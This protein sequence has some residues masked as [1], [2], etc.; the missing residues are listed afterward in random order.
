MIR[1]DA[2][3]M[4]AALRKQMAKLD[5][6]AR[7]LGGSWT[8]V[9]AAP[10]GESDKLRVFDRGRA[11]QP[12]RPLF[13]LTDRDRAEIQSAIRQKFLASMVN[14]SSPSMLVVMTVAANKAREVWVR[15]LS[16][17]GA[18][19]TWAPLSPAYAA[20]KRRKGLD[21][22]IGVA[23]GA[24]LRALRTGHVVVRKTP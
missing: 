24:M 4:T 9:V 15:R 14:T 16:S 20:R 13:V 11:N 7:E 6:M 8:C 18:D 19:Q 3:K 10:P 23:T 2:P 17:S 5:A 1:L 22:R 12:A 21:A